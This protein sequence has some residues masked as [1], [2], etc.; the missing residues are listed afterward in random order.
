MRKGNEIEIVRHNTMGQLEIF[1]VEMISRAP[2]GH[3]D[4]EMGILLD[5]NMTIFLDQKPY[6][7]IKG[8]IYIINRF[9]V[10]SFLRTTESNR[11][12][13][14]QIHPDFY[15]NINPSLGALH[16][17]NNII[18]SGALHKQLTAALLSGAHAYF[19]ETLE[20]QINCSSQLLA[21]MALLLKY[22]YYSIASRQETVSDQNN[23]LRLN[24]IMD[25]I[26]DH[27]TE[28]LSLEQ[29]AE[30]EHITTFHASH[31]IRNMLGMSFQQYVNQVRFEHA[32]TL[33]ETTRLSATDVCLEVG[34]SS[35]RYLNQMFETN[36]HCSYKEYMHAAEKPRLSNVALPTGNIQK[37][38]SFHVSKLLLGKILPGHK[39]ADY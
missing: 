36:L 3:D 16:F 21:A 31:F 34:F 7:L 28:K 14:F 27:Y 25:Y 33:F 37:R 38:F 15:K 35:T 13:A 23:T 10:H 5:G 29:L 30:M 17:E 18:H 2:H 32:L 11:I 4:L 9:Q 24:R 26:A 19:E 20:G 1:L 22:S 39:I 6:Q 12:L 8:D